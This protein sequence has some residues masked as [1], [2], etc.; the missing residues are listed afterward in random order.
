[1]GMYK[2]IRDAW[3]APSNNILKNQLKDRLVQWRKEPATVRVTKPTRLDRARSLGYRAKQGII[4]VRQRLLRGGRQNPK[5]Q[6][7]RRSK[8]Q[9][10]RKDLNVSYQTI[11]EQRVAAK[12]VNCEVLNSYYVAE[13]G[14]YYWYEVIIV[15][16]NSPAIKK[17]KQLKWISIT[18]HTNRVFRGLTS[19]AKKSRGLSYKGKGSEKTRPSQKARGNKLK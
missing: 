10:R 14:R 5:P 3:K 11:A 16:K 9:T 18:K 6:G 12:Y 13:D 19:S 8:R 17:D 4:V 1:M 2:Y 7:G 15:D